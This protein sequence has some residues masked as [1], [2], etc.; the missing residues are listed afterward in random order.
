MLDG[1]MLLSAV[2]AETGLSDWGDPTFPTRFGLAID[3]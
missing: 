1:A 2:E 3:R